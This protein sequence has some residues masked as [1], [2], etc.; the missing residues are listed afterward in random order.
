VHLDTPHGLSTHITTRPD[1]PGRFR[2]VAH[3][4]KWRSTFFA[5]YNDAHYASAV[6]MRSFCSSIEASHLVW[7]IYCA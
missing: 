7:L 5:W 1:Y 4:R 6:V 2:D 3:L